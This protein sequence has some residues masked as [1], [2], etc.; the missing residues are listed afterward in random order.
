MLAEGV[1]LGSMWL[2]ALKAKHNSTL[3]CLG[4]VFHSHRCLWLPDCMGCITEP[5]LHVRKFC[6]STVLSRLPQT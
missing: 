4:E 1:V 6:S 5:F 3:R 2:L